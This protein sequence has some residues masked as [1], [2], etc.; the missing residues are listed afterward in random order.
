[1]T[2][3]EELDA[4]L[5][6]LGGDLDDAG[7]DRRT[8]RFTGALRRLRNDPAEAARIDTLAADAWDARSR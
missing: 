2:A 4:I 8:A 6:A 7:I 3:D 1:M 5:A